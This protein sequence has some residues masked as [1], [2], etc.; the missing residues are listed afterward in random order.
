[1]PIQYS[2]IMF[3]CRSLVQVSVLGRGDLLS[4]P[5]TLSAQALLPCSIWLMDACS[6][7]TDKSFDYKIHPT[8]TEVNPLGQPLKGRLHPCWS[9]ES[10]LPPP[11]ICISSPLH[12]HPIVTNSIRYYESNVDL[13]DLK[14]YGAYIKSSIYYLSLSLRSS[15]F[16]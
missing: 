9:Q 5:S 7:L 10:K 6:G 11:L 16:F 15:F 8:H 4:G 3:S 12:I 14:V 1:V 2:S 13:L